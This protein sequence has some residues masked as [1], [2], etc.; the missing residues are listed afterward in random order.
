M[1]KH[2]FLLLAFILSLKVF[3][4][5]TAS[6]KA[7][8]PTITPPSPTVAALMKFE[9][10][11]V[12]NYTGIPSVSIPI[13]NIGTMSKDIS[14]NVSLDYH[15][16][17]TS[18]DEIASYTGLGWSLIAGGT[19][20]RTIKGLADERFYIGGPTIRTA[21]GIYNNN[22]YNITFGGANLDTPEFL[23]QSFEKGVN[24]TEHDLYQFNFMGHTGRFYV[25]SDYGDLEVVKLYENENLKIDVNYT[26]VAQ[27]SNSW[28]K[29]TIYGFTIYD[30]KGYKFIFGKLNPTDNG[31][32]ENTLVNRATQQTAFNNILS[33]NLGDFDTN[34]TSAFHLSQII[35]SNNNILAEFKYTDVQENILKSE[36]MENHP[37]P[38]SL[39]GM[40]KGPPADSPE[41]GPRFEGIIPK[42]VTT[43]ITTST[44]T[45]KLSQIIITNKAN[46]HF[47]LEQ[48][49]QDYPFINPTTTA[50][51]KKIIIKDWSDSNT[52]K[53]FQLGYNYSSLYK[54]PRLMLK[55]VKELNSLGTLGLP[56][57]MSYR[58]LDDDVYVGEIGRDYWGYYNEKPFSLSDDDVAEYR[59]TS[60]KY[61]TLDVLQKMTFP[62]GGCQVFDFESNRYSFVGDTA[63]TN[64]DDNP[65]NMY[66]INSFDDYY[67][68]ELPYWDY[69]FT[70]TDN[71]K[72][73]R[74]SSKDQYVKAVYASNEA[75]GGMNINPIPDFTYGN[76][77]YHEMTLLHDV[78]YTISWG[79]FDIL[80]GATGSALFMYQEKK[81]PQY[82]YLY[83]G[84][85]RIRKI[86]YFKENDVDALYY[87]N[88]IQ[89]GILPSK[90]KTYD[91]SLFSDID[92]GS[93]ADLVKSSGALVFPKPVFNYTVS[94][95]LLKVT[96]IV[97]E[98]GM[99]EV[100][101]KEL[102]SVAFNTTTEFNNL[103][104][105]RTQGS[106]VGY[107]NV[108]VS[109][110]KNGYSRYYYT[111]PLTDPEDY[112]ASYPF[113]ASKNIDYRRGLVKKEEHFTE[114][115]K[116]LAETNYGYEFV[117]KVAKT[118]FTGY[119]ESGCPISTRYTNYID[120]V[121]CLNDETC[122]MAVGWGITFN[123]NSYLA[124]RDIE[125]AF[126]W[127]K[128][129]TIS[130]KKYF[131]DDSD[132]RHT[133]QTDETFTYNPLNKK[134]ATH[135]VTSNQG[136]LETRYFYSTGDAPTFFNRISEID[137]IEEYRDGNLLSTSKIKY[138]NTFPGN[139]SF[140]PA[141]ILTA[142]GTLPLEE[143]LSYD[144][145]DSYSHLIQASR[146]DGT[147]VSYIWGYN[148]SQVVT[149]IENATYASIPSSLLANVVSASNTNTEASLILDQTALRN[150]MPNA[151]VTTYTYLPLVGLSTV[152]DPKGD[153]IRYI[154]DGFGR[155]QTVKDKNDNV[156]S[157]NEYYY[158]NQN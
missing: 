33:D 49:R 95:N 64:F 22:Y 13:T 143:R 55:E 39:E 149:K 151:M 82:P 40:L 71:T 73:L 45:K 60:K 52:I 156:L 62:T 61:C 104:S 69:S 125:E 107:S 137:H 50:K 92:G 97:D 119:S 122:D 80:N 34:Y 59:G 44:A 58:H 142:K 29:Y 24:D 63:L 110:F 27:D 35:D 11:G 150:G 124:H 8:M 66:T 23:W 12:N 68:Y 102:M 99:P 153:T 1:K 74:L 113:I 108:K 158:E 116:K 101:I 47:E 84:G 3:C 123:L 48:G 86:G 154:Y 89:N 14:I 10:V 127:A 106:D 57:T 15:A 53:Q 134:I 83:G 139:Q 146:I 148:N 56:Y 144:R 128:L 42:I 91:Y 81:V 54:G 132:D 67:E 98:P 79:W 136:L 85:I 5:T 76:G 117:D 32:I 103:L 2:I 115:G 114:D 96:P 17:S 138:A 88:N 140:L 41:P 121:N 51:L 87:S 118:G 145:Y 43:N 9:E 105:I 152:T 94:K 109:E 133:V 135:T 70:T 141:L 78:Q 126:G 111:S 129:D 65:D 131:Y 18:T 90:E 28:T 147:Y 75:Q 120:L 21:K 31:P 38:L 100:S 26:A 25:A 112:S 72:N 16:G 93:P 7:D 20:S 37:V 30:D 157:E 155:L 6:I 36:R 46:I 130:T 4:Q 77:N 19:I